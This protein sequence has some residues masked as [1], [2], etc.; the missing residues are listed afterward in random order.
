MESADAAVRDVLA[1]QRERYRVIVEQLEASV[2]VVVG[3]ILPDGGAVDDVVHE[4]FFTAF[5]KLREYQPGTDLRAWVNAIARN[6]ALNER[7][8]WLKR[9]G[10]SAAGAEVAIEEA[11][12]PFIDQLTA[13]VDGETIRHLRDCVGRLGEAAR[14]V[15]ERHYFDGIPGVEIARAERRKESWVHLVLYRARAAIAACLEARGVRGHG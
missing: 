2:R 9:R 1:G 10:E 12:G 5:L 15:V 7:R 11:A 4:V 8:R 13:L 14:R 6:L 3:A